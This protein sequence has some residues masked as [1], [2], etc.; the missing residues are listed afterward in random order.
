MKIGILGTGGVGQTIAARLEGLKH[1]VMIGTR[2]PKATLA[3]ADKDAMGNAPYR[4]WAAQHG[5]VRLGTFA[6][7]AR[8]GEL[9]VNA[10]S[11][12]A[13]MEALKSAG[14]SALN[15]KTLLDISNP[16]DFSKGMPPSL[17]ISNTDSLGEQIQKAFPQVRVVKSL[18]T[19]NAH[20]MVFPAELAGADHTVFV[21][22]NDAGAK[23]QVTELLKSFGW[24]HIQDM[25]DIT[26]ARGTE[27]LLPIWVRL[28]GVLGSP[29]FN[30]KI[31]K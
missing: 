26:T 11:G 15:G 1:D 28:W 24:K 3:K 5:Q 18:N 22:G 29:Q 21:S 9:V 30:F 10:T 14:E 6:E 23:T 16:L 8:H 17:F 12:H 31:V 25:G 2:D 4:D 13:S 7:A 20:L 19:M 27:M